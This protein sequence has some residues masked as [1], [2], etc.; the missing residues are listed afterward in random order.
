MSLSAEKAQRQ[1]TTGNLS[2]FKLLYVEAQD[3]SYKS[4]TYIFK[5]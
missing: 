5:S 4:Y 2:C 1:K 3:Q